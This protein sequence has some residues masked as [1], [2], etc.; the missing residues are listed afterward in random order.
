[1]CW[2]KIEHRSGDDAFPVVVSSGRIDV[3]MP[4]DNDDIRLTGIALIRN[5]KLTDTDYNT[6]NIKIID[7]RIQKVS[8]HMG[9]SSSPWDV[10]S[11]STD[12]LAVT[13][14][15]EHIIQFMSGRSTLSTVRRLMVDGQCMGMPYGR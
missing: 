12:I 10:T 11:L 15:K 1:M 14:T 2:C 7:L 4:D 9:L 13:L 6:C 5:D 8:Y 3:G